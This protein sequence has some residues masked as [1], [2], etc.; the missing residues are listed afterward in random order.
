MRR[1]HPAFM[2]ALVVPVQ[3]WAQNSAGKELREPCF[4]SPGLGIPACT[5]DPGHVAIEVEAG[6]CIQIARQHRGLGRSPSPQECTAASIW[7]R[8]RQM[9]AGNLM[10]PDTYADSQSIS[11][12]VL[13]LN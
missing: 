3:A 7:P 6:D 5:L 4:D 8:C 10:L 1:F 2:F 9:C 12:S 13:E 11:Q